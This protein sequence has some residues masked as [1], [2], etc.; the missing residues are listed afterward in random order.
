MSIYDMDYYL[1]W[2][3]LTHFLFE[4]PKHRPACLELLGGGGRLETF[5]KLIGPVDDV[6]RDWYAHVA[7]IK[8]QLSGSDLKRKVLK[9]DSASAATNT[10]VP[11]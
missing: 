4:T 10:S 3:T 6:Q 7:R 8:A 2:W 1:H 9:P 5:E 11:R